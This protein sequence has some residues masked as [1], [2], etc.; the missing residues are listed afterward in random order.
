MH[1]W[2]EPALIDHV[3][4]VASLRLYRH[5][6]AETRLASRARPFRQ[7]CGLVAQWGYNFRMQPHQ[8]SSLSPANQQQ[9]HSDVSVQCYWVTQGMGSLSS[10]ELLCHFSGLYMYPWGP[11]RFDESL[12]SQRKPGSR[13]SQDL[14]IIGAVSTKCQHL[15]YQRF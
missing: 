6:P 9:S 7:R 13:M 1:L 11:I 2:G 10:A 4:L 15:L 12:P 14:A 5:T 8:R 3:P